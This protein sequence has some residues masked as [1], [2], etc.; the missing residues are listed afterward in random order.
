MHIVLETQRLT[1]RQFTEDDVDNLFD[2][3]RATQR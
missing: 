3:N 1:L 2:L